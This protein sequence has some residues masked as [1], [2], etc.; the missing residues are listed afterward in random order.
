MVAAITYAMYTSITVYVNHNHKNNVNNNKVTD[1]D[2]QNEETTIQQRVRIISA[3][4]NIGN[5]IVDLLLLSYIHVNKGSRSVYWERERELGSD[6]EAGILGLAIVNLLA[7]ICSIFPYQY[8]QKHF[9]FPLFWNSFLVAS[10]IFVPIVW[11][12]FIEEGLSSWPY[13][14]IFVWFAISAMELSAFSCSWTYY[15]IQTN[16]TSSNTTKKDD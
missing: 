9:T 4:S 14:I 13:F 3:W 12:R 16:N 11:L 10:G 2:S 5:S 15:L 6:G 8:T 7:G 1:N